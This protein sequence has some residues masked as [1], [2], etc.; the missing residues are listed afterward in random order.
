[1]KYLI[2]HKKEFTIT[3]VALI[4]AIADMLKVFGVDMPIDKASVY[5]VV[6]AV[7]GVLVW[8]Y[9]MPTSKENCEHTGAMRLEKEQAKGIITGEDFTDEAEEIKEK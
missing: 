5:A 4:V 9:N 2:K 6:S 8:F 3:V 7:M 1:M